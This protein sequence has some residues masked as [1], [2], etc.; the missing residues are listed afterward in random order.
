M[1]QSFSRTSEYK[2]IKVSAGK[3]LCIFI[4]MEVLL[5]SVVYGLKVF[6]EFFRNRSMRLIEKAIQSYKAESKV[7]QTIK[8]L[9]MNAWAKTAKY[10]LIYCL[11]EAKPENVAICYRL[12]LLSNNMERILSLVEWY[13]HRNFATNITKQIVRKRMHENI[14]IDTMN[15]NTTMSLNRRTIDRLLTDEEDFPCTQ[16][17]PDVDAHHYENSS[18]HVTTPRSFVSMTM[19][20]FTSFTPASSA[21]PRTPV[22][23]QDDDNEIE[24]L[25]RRTEEVRKRLARLEDQLKAAKRSRIIR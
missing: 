16:P 10:Q 18:T 25:E 6:L 7:D 1:D 19:K 22:Y 8:A 13:R 15:S 5:T 4:D 9:L 20:S 3:L 14:V 11:P 17:I 21:P 2:L 24:D 12:T 23:T